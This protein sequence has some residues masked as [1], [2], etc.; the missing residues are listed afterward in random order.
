[1]EVDSF[2]LYKGVWVN[3]KAPHLSSYLNK[4]TYNK[5]LSGG[6]YLL[7]NTYDFDCKTPTSFWYVIKDS[8]GGMEELPAK[9]RNQVKRSLK[10]LDVRP[11]SKEELLEKGYSVYKAACGSYKVKAAI[12]SEKSFQQ[13]IKSGGE[14]F[15]GAFLKANGD[16][17]AFSMN[18]LSEDVCNYSTMKADPQYMTSA[19][20]PYYGLLYEMNR[21]YLEECKL[22]Y[23]NDG[24]RTITEHSGVQDFLI[25]KFKFRKAYCRLQIVYQWWFHPF[26]Y[27]LYPFRK[28]IPS[29]KVRS[30]L[31]MEAMRRGEI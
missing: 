4:V 10:T 18:N 13:R 27:L 6:G 15:W 24:A 2:R 12:P 29:L 9:T 8:F 23:V 31:N 7:R 11:I 1:M 28:I 17:V 22:R 25:D 26:I 30:I 16:L 14:K 20:Y 19:Y 5:I 21:Y 3:N